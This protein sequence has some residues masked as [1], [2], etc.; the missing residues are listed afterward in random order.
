MAYSKCTKMSGAIKRGIPPPPSVRLIPLIG[1]AHAVPYHLTDM[2]T[3]HCHFKL[4]K[5]SFKHLRMLT[6]LVEFNISWKEHWVQRSLI[7]SSHFQSQ[8]TV[9]LMTARD[10]RRFS[11][12]SLHRS[13]RMPLFQ[14]STLSPCSL[15]IARRGRRQRNV[16]KTLI[17]PIPLTPRY[18]PTWLPQENWK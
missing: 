3:H 17:A 8:P 6:R 14:R 13:C 15:D 4:T 9:Q 10:F 7:W 18:S 2:R 5:S 16:R 1:S 12:P 11:F